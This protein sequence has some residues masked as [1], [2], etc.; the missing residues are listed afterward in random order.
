MNGELIVLRLVHILGGVFWVGSALFTSIFLIPALA[1][2]GPAAGQ[3][4]AGLQGRRL[5]TVLPVVAVLTI[6]SGLRLMQLTSGGFSAVYFEQTAGQAYTA[7]AVAA[8]LAFILSIV[9]ARPAAVRSA[10]IAAQMATSDPST[11]PEL[12]REL[13]GLRRRGAVSSAIAVTLLVLGAA[14][15]A[16][17][18][19]LR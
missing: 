5:F 19:Y 7:S 18:R 13:E 6:L 12:V 14:G 9:V 11:R 16:I 15:M 1:G 17:A 8:T 2:V 3:V 10:R 4:M